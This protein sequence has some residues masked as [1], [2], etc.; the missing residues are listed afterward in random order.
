M[1]GDCL[2]MS[3]NCLNVKTIS[4]L[5]LLALGITVNSSFSAVEPG[6]QE[7]YD[8]S[9]D[10]QTCSTYYQKYEPAFYTGFAPRCREPDR[11]HLHVGRGNQLR[12]TLVLSDDVLEAY[13]RD[14]R[15]RYT[16][17]RERIDRGD[18]T[19]TQNSSFEKFEKIIRELADPENSEPEMSRQDIIKSNL[20]LITRLN[21]GRIF[22][23]SIPV[24][25][26]IGN[27]QDFLGK[28]DS[29]KIDRKRKLAIINEMLPT[30]LWVTDLDGETASR[31][32]DLIK[33]ATEDGVTDTLTGDYLALL[34]KVSGGIYPRKDNKFDFIE[35]T[36]IYPVGTFNSYTTCSGGEKIPMYPTPGKWTMTSHQRTKTADH[37]PEI[38]IY[39]WFPWLPYMHVGDKLHNSFHTLWWRME[40]AKT[41]FLPEELRKPQIKSREGKEYRYLWL[42]SRG[43]M[44]HGCTHVNGGHILELRQLLPAS[45][46]EMYDVAF[47][48]NKSCLF[49][50]FDINGDL[51][52]EVMGVRYYVAYTLKEKKPGKL[53]A[54]MERRPYYKWLYGGILK[55]DVAGRG[56]F[57]N[58]RDGRFVEKL[59]V[60]GQKFKKISLYE[61]EMEPFRLQF[62]KM[63]SLRDIPDI[64]E[65]RKTGE[66]YR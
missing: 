26:V 6:E 1:P 63:E 55:Y 17:Y 33:L 50:V 9:P 38:S 14:L 24:E 18:L 20:L 60:A 48:L 25:R 57:E 65:L 36:A 21:P 27:W 8:R 15:A 11:L 64:R 49:D 39:S 7:N 5:C 54:A 28:A 16:T 47:Y 22:T 23:I 46:K 32:D 4:I 61:A 44:S 56:Y 40:H 34:D 43:P 13:V 19:L 53:R 35:F 30:R 29:G 10:M 3:S 45:E 37:I 31:L 66:D 51:E 12:A 59:A 52:P 42:L 62:F 58:I 41:S 2:I